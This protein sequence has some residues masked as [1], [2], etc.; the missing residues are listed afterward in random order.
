[1]SGRRLSVVWIVVVALLL[2]AAFAGGI[3]VANAQPAAD[4]PRGGATAAET[5]DQ[6]LAAL[7]ANDSHA[8]R[9]VCTDEALNRTGKSTPAMLESLTVESASRAGDVV[10]NAAARTAVA[11]F[12]WSVSLDVERLTD[13]LLRAATRDKQAA[14]ASREELARALELVRAVLAAT[15]RNLRARIEAPSQRMHLQ[16]DVDGRWFV[17]QL[18]DPVAA[19]SADSDGDGLQNGDEPDVPVNGAE[20]PEDAARAV[21]S[22]WRDDNIDQ[23]IAITRPGEFRDTLV[24]D[25]DKEVFARCLTIQRVQFGNVW[26]DGHHAWVQYL[27]HVAFDAPTWRT[28]RLQRIETAAREAGK[29]DMA[30]DMMAAAAAD[31]ISAGIEQLMR[32]AHIMLVERHDDSRW[33]VVNQPFHDREPAGISPAYNVDGIRVDDHRAVVDPGYNPPESECGGATPEALARRVITAWQTDNMIDVVWTARPVVRGWYRKQDRSLV[34]CIK[35]EKVE[36]DDV[37]E[38]GNLAWVRYRWR[39][40]LLDTDFYRYQRAEIERQLKAGEITAAAAAEQMRTLPE[41]VHGLKTQIEKAEHVMKIERV[42]ERW[43]LAGPFEDREPAFR[44]TRKADGPPIEYADD[45]EP[46]EK[47]D[48]TAPDIDDDGLQDGGPPAESTCG[49]DTPE[50]LMKRLLAAWKSHTVADLVW[51]AHPDKREEQKKQDNMIVMC[52]TVQEFKLEK[53]WIRGAVAHVSWS[54]RAR[55]DDAK[56]YE[57]QVAD[58]EKRAR[59]QGVK[60]EALEQMKNLVRQ[61]VLQ[62]KHTVEAKD[63]VTQM[64][65]HSN[66]RW[67]ST[68]GLPFHDRTPAYA[69]TRDA[70]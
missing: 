7:V 31:E 67:Y 52:T 66:N 43:Y 54:W 2:A 29:S 59:E 26:R 22:A 49:G 61:K 32:P 42:G 62:M 27:W 39:A 55:F 10:V 16:Q 68:A 15:G 36:L 6:C 56:F 58:L 38:Q 63:H 13:A 20:T 50:A 25:A 70:R 5:A 14:N 28:H 33:Y 21:F 34:K 17:T 37:W 9:N 41:T 53:V 19:D 4:G 51:C 35:V 30:I 44:V 8:F 65:S 40:R 57:H 11:A 46:G 12:T 18:V 45:D 48:E 47:K 1:M 60:D 69:A 23:L 3:R 24:A 64:Q